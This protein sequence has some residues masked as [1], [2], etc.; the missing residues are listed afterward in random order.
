[1]EIL[2]TAPLE[3]DARAVHLEHARSLS[4]S[5]RRNLPRGG[6]GRRIPSVG[7]DPETVLA[8][9]IDV[10]LSLWTPDLAPQFLLARVNK[11]SHFGPPL[12]GERF[13]G[14]VDFSLP[15]REP[16]ASARPPDLRR[17]D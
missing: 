15:Q 17:A 12:A 5:P 14:G 13:E 9:R 8:G 2:H 6:D 11:V 3:A 1:M 7:I 4:Q 10:H 16:R